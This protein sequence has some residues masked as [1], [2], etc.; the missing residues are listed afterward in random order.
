MKGVLVVFSTLLLLTLGASMVNAGGPIPNVQVYF[1][2]DWGTYGQTALVECPDAPHNTVLDSFYV[3]ASNFNM[4]MIGIEYFL[5][6]PFQINPLA[7]EVP[8][9]GLV[10][11]TAWIFPGIA[12]SWPLPQNAFVPFAVTKIK[13]LYR[14][15]LCQD[16]TDICIHVLNHQDT[17]FVRAVRW[18]DITFVNGIGMT[19]M[20]CPTVPVE[21]TTWG[22][23]KALYQN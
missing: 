1:T 7:Q 16:G 15:T 14:C 6:L 9:G 8:N 13:F 2:S 21:E 11:G 17:G 5:S 20:I 10:I 23:I 18:P 22:G 3:V 4:W 19:S 12:I